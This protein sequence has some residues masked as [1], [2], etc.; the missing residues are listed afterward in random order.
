MRVLRSV[1]QPAFDA[2]QLVR[3]RLAAERPYKLPGLHP[4]F[5]WAFQ[6]HLFGPIQLTKTIN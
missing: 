2:L 1:S 6:D 3:H 5:A 4:N